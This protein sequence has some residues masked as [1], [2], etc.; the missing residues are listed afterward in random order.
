MEFSIILGNQ[1]LD[2]GHRCLVS[3]SHKEL[4]VIRCWGTVSPASNVREF[5]FYF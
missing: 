1:R 4:P 2:E 5:F 3:P